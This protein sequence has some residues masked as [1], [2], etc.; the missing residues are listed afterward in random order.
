MTFAADSVNK[1][2]VNKGVAAPGAVQIGRPGAR[3]AIPDANAMTIGANYT[4]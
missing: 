1:Y 2:V 3:V 4:P